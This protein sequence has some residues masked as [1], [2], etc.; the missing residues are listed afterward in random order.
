MART[1]ASLLAPE[2]DRTT[3][4]QLPL[5]LNDSGARG[6][7]ERCRTRRDATIVIG[8]SVRGFF[9]VGRRCPANISADSAVR[10]HGH[11][12]HFLPSIAGGGDRLFGTVPLAGPTARSSA[13]LEGK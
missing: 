10:Q 4:L 3:H 5:V 9:S 2:V 8:P 6:P 1:T 11:S 7:P 13:G 12:S